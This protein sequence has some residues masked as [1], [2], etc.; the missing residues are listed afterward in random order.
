MTDP[1]SA[2]VWSPSLAELTERV[3]LPA[4]ADIR[5]GPV[6]YDHEGTELEGLLAA[7]P[8]RAA[9]ARPCS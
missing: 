9:D 6:L 8:R 5:M 4:G 1:A 3:P 2:P 7:T